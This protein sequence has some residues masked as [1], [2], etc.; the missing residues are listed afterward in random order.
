MEYLLVMAL[1]GTTM[2]VMYLLLRRLLKKKLCAKAYYFL[3]KV[4]VLYYLIPLPFLKSW[5]RD[6]VPTAVLERRMGLDRISLTWTNVAVHA[7]GN[8]HVNSYAVIQTALAVVW[9]LGACVRLAKRL[10]RYR[11]V[12]RWYSG[13]AK[14]TMTEKERLFAESLRKNYG[15]RRRVSFIQARDG[16][17]TFTFG[18]LRPIIICGKEAGSREAE[19]LAGHEM[20]HI[21]RLDVFWK[22]LM[23]AAALLHWWNPF[24]KKLGE[25]FD[26]VCECSC[27]EVTLRDRTEDEGKAYMRLM[28]EEARNGERDKEQD[29]KQNKEPEGPEV[30][31]KAGFGSH[32]NEIR[33]RV[34]NLKM[35]KKWNRLATGALVAALILGNSMTVFAYRDGY[36]ET[37]PEDVTQEEVEFVLDN[38]FAVFAPGGT[39]WEAMQNGE[40]EE[41]I[42]LFYEKQFIDEEG[43]VYLVFEEEGVEPYCNHSYVSGELGEHHPYSDGSCEMRIYNA[44]RC[45]RC[46]HII[47]GD[48]IRKI[49]FDPCPH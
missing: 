2:T 34:E 24:M 5:Y 40:M 36:S 20:V 19:F 6:M 28:I 10:V 11:E 13:Y 8:L 38:D 26:I 22:I 49:A 42:H 21:R 39:D 25:D 7:H 37:L 15:V 31:W 45:V 17:P 12:V 47:R 32:T 3:A 16:D 27:D 30:S 1:S 4:A 43:N 35:K 9:F 48:L 18:V 44:E 29:K 46:G 14:K 41:E 33:E 23:E